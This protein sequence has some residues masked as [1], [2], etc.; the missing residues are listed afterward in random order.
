MVFAIAAFLAP[1]TLGWGWDWWKFAGA[2]IAIFLCFRWARPQTFVSELGLRMGR[3]DLCLGGAS[4]LLTGLVAGHLIPRILRP[5]GYAAGTSDTP[6]WRFLATPFQVLNEEMILRAFLLVLLMRLVK[7]PLAAS[8]VTAGLAAGVHFLL[9]RFGPPRAA[10]SIGA[11]TTL[12][13][14]ALA[15]NQFFFS[16]GNIAVPF[17]IHLGWNFTRFGHDWI[18][19]SS[20]ENLPEGM[21]FN[22]IEGNI[23]VMAL[24]AILLLAAVVA[25]RLFGNDPRLFSQ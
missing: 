21:D 4:L 16:S 20:G 14:V 18:A 23:A 7:R 19:Q 15:L 17:G 13:L 2:S 24:A 10:L 25:N 22:L 1:Y 12:F 8:V 9:Y 11:L 6:A 5:L 3:A